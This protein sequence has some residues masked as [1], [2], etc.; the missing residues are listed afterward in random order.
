MSNEDKPNTL[1]IRKQHKSG[2]TVYFRLTIKNCDTED[3]QFLLI[4]AE[5]ISEIQKLSVE[6]NYQATHDMM[7]GLINRIEF[8]RR[9]D[10]CIDQCKKN[11]SQKK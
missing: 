5:D 7:T 10:N 11:C 8:E 1:E 2:D 9:L 6:L 4:V 3:G